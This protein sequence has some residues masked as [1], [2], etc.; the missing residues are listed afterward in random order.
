MPIPVQIKTLALDT[1]V[2]VFNNQSEQQFTVDVRGRPTDVLLDNEGWVLKNVAPA[3]LVTSVLETEQEP[4]WKVYPNPATEHV[5]IEFKLQLPSRVIVKI[6]DPNG[7][8]IRLLTNDL[9][10]T[11]T[12]FIKTTLFS[13]PTGFY[14]IHCELGDETWTKKLL[15]K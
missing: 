10:P 9:Y 6:L 4:Q 7:Q 12:H 13:I 1:T 14:L 5:T 15:V 2:I 11:G 3:N 8:L